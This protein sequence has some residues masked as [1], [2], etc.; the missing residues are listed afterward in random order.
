MTVMVAGSVT[1]PK[2]ALRPIYRGRS[3]AEM[4]GEQRATPADRTTVSINLS[5]DILCPTQLP[6]GISKSGRRH[7]RGHKQAPEVSQSHRAMPTSTH[8]KTACIANWLFLL[9]GPLDEAQ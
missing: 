6:L 7:A 4:I 5:A 2:Q 8:L 3:T 9:N 1:G